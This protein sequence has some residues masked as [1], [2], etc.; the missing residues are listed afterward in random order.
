MGNLAFGFSCAYDCQEYVALVN[1]AGQTMARRA[2]GGILLVLPIMTAG[3][4][5]ASGRETLTKS[6][7]VIEV[8][9]RDE[10]FGD[11]FIQE[12]LVRGPIFGYYIGLD[13]VIAV[14]AACLMIWLVWRVA[15]YLRRNRPQRGTL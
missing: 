6:A 14:A 4:W 2:F 12:K 1:D 3:L 8:Q 7:R 11:T 9:A 10:L 5:L 13:L 15:R